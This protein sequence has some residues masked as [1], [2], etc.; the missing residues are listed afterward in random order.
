[1][2]MLRSINWSDREE[3]S[4]KLINGVCWSLATAIT[5]V[6]MWVQNQIDANVKDFFFGVFIL[7]SFI[8]LSQKHEQFNFFRCE[9]QPNRLS[10]DR[11]LTIPE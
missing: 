6:R 5:I 4:Q 2:H 11:R 8:F 10:P 9:R 7:F 3:S 1:M